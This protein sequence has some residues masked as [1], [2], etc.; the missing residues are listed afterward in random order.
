MTPTRP[1]ERTGDAT[2]TERRRPSYAPGIL[3]PKRLGRL[4]LGV[5][6]IL[7][8]FVY[9]GADLADWLL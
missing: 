3:E 1:N 6:A 8:A 7:A 4:L 2:R 5:V 9:A